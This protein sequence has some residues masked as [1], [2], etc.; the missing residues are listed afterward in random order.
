LAGTG[1]AVAGTYLF[2]RRAAWAALTSPQRPIDEDGYELW[3][4]YRQVDRPNLLAS[5]RRTVSHVVVPANAGQIASSATAE[6]VR[7]L[8]GLLGRDVPKETAPAGD[9]AVILGT[10]DSSALISRHVDTAELE[11]LGPEGYVLRRRRVDDADAVL[12]ASVGERGVLYGAFHLLRLL[13]TQR[14]ITR[15]DITERPTNPL[16]LVNHWDNLNRSVERGY[17][18][19]SIF[20]WEELPETL[21]HYNDYARVR[22]SVGIN[23]TVVNN[24]NANADFLASDRLTGLAALA[25]V[26]REWGVTFHLSANYASPM[27]LGGLDTAD[28]ADPGVRQ[29]W[30][31]KIDEIYALIPDFGGFLVK[32]NSEG[33]PG[34]LDYGRTHAEGA[35]MLAERVDPHGGII[36]WRSF[37]HEGFS[38]WAEYQHRVFAPLDGDFAA[39]VVLQTKNRP[40]DSQVREPVNPLFGAMPNTNQVIELQITQEYTGQSTHLCYLVPMWKEVLDFDTYMQGPGTTVARIVDGSAYGQSTVGFAGVINFGDDRNWTGHHLA[41][42]NTHGYARLAWNPA[43]DAADIA[44]EWVRMTFGSHAQVVQVLTRIL[45]SSWEIYEDYTTPLGIGGHMV[46]PGGAHFEPNPWSSASLSHHTDARGTGFDRTIA[47]GT[48]YPGLY[49]EHWANLYESLESCPDELLLF[50]HWVPYTH[51]LQSGKTVIQHIY[52]THFEGLDD[53]HRLRKLWETFGKRVDARRHDEV[54]GRFDRQVDHA[55]LWRDTIVGYFF[56]YS[57]ILDEDRSWLQMDLR[58][59]SSLLFGGWPNRLAAE[60]GNATADDLTVRATIVAPGDN[61]IVS[62]GKREIASTE[63]GTVKLPVMPPLM[64]ANVTLDIDLEPANLQ[65][66]GATGQDFVV[67]PAARRCLLALDAGSP[68]SPLVSDYDRLTPQTTW[69]PK[70]GFGWVGSP[71]QSRDRGSALDALRRDFVNDIPA[72]TLRIAI[73]A[74]QHEAAVL[75]GDA[76]PDSHPTFISVDGQRVAESP[77]LPGGTFTWLH[78]TIDG[79]A[80]GR[81]VDLEFDSVPDQ[82]WRLCALVIADPDSQLPPVVMTDVETNLAWTSGVPSDVAVAVVNTTTDRTVPVTV[83]VEVPDGWTAEPVTRSLAPGGEQIVRAQVTPSPQPALATPTVRVLADGAEVGDGTRRLDIVTVPPGDSVALALDAGGPASPVLDG[84]R[85]L[86]PEDTWDPAVGYGWVGTV[87]E[88]RDRARLDDVRR[89]LVFGRPP[90]P[91][92][93]RLAVPAGEHRI[94]VLTGDAYATASETVVSID[95]VVVGR[96]GDSTIPQGSF[97]WFDFPVDGGGSG[98]TV[99]LELTG[100]LYERLWRIVALIMT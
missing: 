49:H 55:T 69:D 3:L 30:Q 95:G 42:A 12:I 33:Q 13:Q 74:G 39:N 6:L 37:V 79:G 34:P 68:S 45:T 16:R 99:D 58:G 77:Y 66:L 18:C 20:H 23:D 92:I 25:D 80:S 97:R 21:P 62:P 27:V 51:V 8:T 76:G 1:S 26:F 35:N 46:L 89:D 43:L 63:F 28:P 36:I 4:R 82:H 94:H 54:L 96:S 10:P 14:D 83:E 98:R 17:A 59:A 44:E 29:W 93:L 87:P 61:W 81:E 78:F 85:R 2:D 60:V 72:R 73:P 91:S 9:G 64:A 50:M 86:S 11:R 53:A 22:A 5:Y 52:D 47:T 84:Y 48:G 70:R 19:L 65:T 24:V 38:D 15:L 7:G 88:Y 71:P 32:A 57:K 67:T 56:S 75:V 41:A 40:I 31:D 90:E 100:N